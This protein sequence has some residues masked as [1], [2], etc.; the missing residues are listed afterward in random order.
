MVDGRSAPSLLLDMIVGKWLSQAI[1]V[2]AEMGIADLLKDGPRTSAEIAAETGASEDGVYRLLRALGGVG[3]FTETEGRRFTLANLGTPLRRDV[4]GSVR[5][6]A[7]FVGHEI[8]GRPWGQFIHSVK[9]GMPSF[10]LV[11][12]APVFE[13]LA[14]QPEAAA[15]MNEAMTSLSLT[16]ARAVVSAYDFRGINMLVDVGG[17]HG[18]L[19]AEVLKANP[20]MRAILFELPHA[21]DG[22]RVLLENA[23]VGD[24]CDVVGGDFFTAVPDGGDAYVMKRV[25]HDWDDAH[26][27][28]ILRNCRQAMRPGGKV[29]VVEVVIGSASESHFARL[30]DLEMLVITQGGRERTEEEVRKLYEAAGFRLVR[31]AATGAPVSIVEGFAV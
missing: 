3:L 12:G 22:A 24:R 18:L 5:G 8:N 11:F 13:Y 20:A 2:A 4:A 1:C 28:R 16:E 31:V 27:I 23:G 25:I 6:F 10:D 9:T 21:L 30:L 14:T 15:I 26:S 17:G 29:L 7:R 19:L